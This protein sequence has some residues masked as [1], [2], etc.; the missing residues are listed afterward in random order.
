MIYLNLFASTAESMISKGIKTNEG[1]FTMLN[2]CKVGIA[3]LVLP[4]CLKKEL[5]EMHIVS[6]LLFIALLVFILTIVL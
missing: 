6:V 2:Y 5:Q 3:L 4:V 1:Y